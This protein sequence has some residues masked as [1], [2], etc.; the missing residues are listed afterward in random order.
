MSYSRGFEVPYETGFVV[1][2]IQQYSNDSITKQA[3]FE[4]TSV[5]I[6][7]DAMCSI[8]KRHK[9]TKNLKSMTNYIYLTSE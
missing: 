9:A 3:Y 2:W 4:N 7:S 1:E 8:T 5:S 6:S